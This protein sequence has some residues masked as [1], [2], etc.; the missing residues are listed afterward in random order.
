MHA[1]VTPPFSP[2]RRRVQGAL[3][4]RG[5]EFP[6]LLHH[7]TIDL[8]TAGAV[9]YY[10]MLPGDLRGKDP[11]REIS[12]FR[13]AIGYWW[14]AMHEL[15]LQDDW[16][17]QRHYVMAI[18]YALVNRNK[19]LQDV[20]LDALPRPERIDPKE[21]SLP[22]DTQRRIRGVVNRRDRA[23]VKE[24]LDRALAM[25]QPSREDEV[26]FAK[27][28]E[29]WVDRGVNEYRHSGHEGI[30]R[31][32]GEV[33]N[34]MH[35]YRK[36][37]PPRVRSFINLFSYQAKCSFYLC[38]ANFWASLIPWLQAEHGLNELSTRFLRFWHNQNQP[39]EIPRGQMPSGLVYPTL[40][41]V[42]LMLPNSSGRRV[43][44]R[45]TWLT[46]PIQPQV[47]HDV[48]SGQVLALHPLTRFLFADPVLREVVGQFLNT[49]EFETVARGEST[50][51]CVLYWEMI[52]AILTA[53]HMYRL[54]RDRFAD[55]RGVWERRQDSSPPLTGDKSLPPVNTFLGEY[56]VSRGIRCHCGGGYQCEAVEV[57]SEKEEQTTIQVRC[58][59]CEITKS[60]R[61][62][63]DDVARFLLKED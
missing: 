63:E 43:P 30:I 37:C 2:Q 26:G 15:E 59:R 28:F 1:A 13:S 25:Y 34:W 7:R 32:L 33:D 51:Q 36:R 61:L 54:A 19:T 35:R 58:S 17:Q 6:F 11:M 38:Y 55:S 48:F 49:P 45:M 56:L 21:L 3:Q 29:T 46:P 53:A 8:G 39:I 62:S 31:W 44:H 41:G 20:C 42:E 14:A 27:A 9:D 5:Q 16:D 50:K 23:G 4:L 24:E 40:G 57:I 22:E 52:N 60:I 10:E 18:C 47:M 12:N